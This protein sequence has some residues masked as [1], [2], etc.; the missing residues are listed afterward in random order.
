MMNLSRF[1]RKLFIF[2]D[3]NRFRGE[4]DEE[5]R[6]HRQQA[7]QDFVAAGMSGQDAHYAAMR[8]FGN[9]TRLHER[10][11]E[12]IEFKLETVV[13]DLRYSLRQMRK[14][15]GFAAT[16][17]LILALGIGASAAIF[18]FVDSALIRPLPYE[19]PSQ[20]VALD[21]SSAA[22]A[23]SNLSRD[24]FDDWKRM[25]HS[26][27]SVAAYGMSGFLMKT[28]A[29]MEPVPVARVSD[30][31]FSTLGVKPMLGR[32]FLPG[33]DRP[34]SAKIMVLTYGAW[35]SRFG[36]NAD[37]LGKTLNL[38][39]DNYTIVGVLPREFSFAPRG[40]RD[41]YL[42]LLEKNSCETRRG[43]HNLNGVARLRDGVTVQAALSEMKSI[44]AQLETQYP[45]PNHGQSASVL[46]LEEI[47]VGQVRPILLTL[48]AGAGL[49]LLIASVNVASLMLARSDSRRRETAVR[50]ALGATQFRITR[51]FATEGLVLAVF[52]GAAAALL[53]HW[54][55]KLL[56]S[57][58]P[59]DMM[60]N[61]PFLSDVGL[62]AH[63]VL[64]G[65]GAVLLAALL[66]AATPTLRLVSRDIQNALSDGGRGTAGR[67]W[68]R[69]GSNLVVAELAVA[70]VLLSGAGLLCRSF[71]EL[72]HVETG[73]D[74][75]HI[76][77]VT[78]M[79]PSSLYSKP[80][81][82][83]GLYR[84]IAR[85]VGTL[86]GVLSVGLT[87]DPPLECNCDTDWIRV[88]GMPY[89]GEHDEVNERDVSPAYFDM[90]KA[91]LL[92]GRMF[93][94]TDD[95]S[96]PRVIMINETLA[97]KYFGGQDPIGKNVGNGDLSPDSLRRVIGV[98][99]DVR[100]GALDDEVWPSEYLSI[101][102]DTDSYI[103]V[104][105]RT[106]GDEKALLPELVRTLR[107]IDSNLGLR[108]A[109]TMQQQIDLLQTSV[110]HRF[111]AYLVSGFAAVALLLG[112]V[113]LYGV[114]AYSVSQ[115][116]REIGVRMA[117][118]A[119]RSSVYQ[120]VLGEAG[121]LIAVGVV[122][123][124]AGSVGAAMLMRKLLFGVQA[125][126]A[127]TLIAVAVTLA[128]SALL[129]SYFPARQAAS[130]NPTEA[131]RAE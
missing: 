38:N 106:A 79:A 54:L 60:D 28:S 97:K 41:F 63:V 51:Q 20:L 36:N 70:V 86:P 112:V 55:M 82:Q 56:V 46:P 115:R 101:Y 118:G 71:Y 7:E 125:W 83:V 127:G 47:V 39:G 64:F 121:R 84:E 129:A 92:R 11:H 34:G 37:V 48:L 124:L 111:S 29:G 33:E 42:P 116:T 25:N 73:F 74:T 21:E 22:F 88:E 78:V 68:R 40:N 94:E 98:I 31:F 126:D 53:A 69:V 18:A 102:Q 67:F 91:R 44:A 66:L 96:H 99:R 109:Q 128:G 114:I 45:G 62:N 105:V 103:S 104:M 30:G 72:L 24:D 16:A 14:N 3:R 122:I 52:G 35:Q 76:A 120:M 9:A 26:F 100:E 95:A 131:L 90:L 113:G 2:F 49:L 93:A 89:H 32:L 61:M 12:V 87:S 110:L 85:R 43:C 58:V 8:Q 130:V 75:T 27:V 57:L 65:A 6:F 13:Q 10:S 4:L 123:G 81:Q 1:M 19:K 80:E 17:I 108:G 23:R 15:P 119:Q 107:S 117:L 59:K 77:T 5:M 50:G